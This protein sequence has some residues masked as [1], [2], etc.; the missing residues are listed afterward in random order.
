MADQEWWQ[1]LNQDQGA[2]AHDRLQA[3]Q[4]DERDDPYQ[5]AAR[6]Q[7]A[8]EALQAPPESFRGYSPG[9]DLGDILDNPVTDAA[10]W[11]L[12][13][14]GTALDT[15]ARPVRTGIDEA[16]NL[17]GG[18][19]TDPYRVLESVWNPDAATSA[20]SLRRRFLFKDIGEE[21]DG[22]TWGDVPDVLADLG[23]ATVTDPLSFLLPGASKAGEAAAVGGRKLVGALSQA[24]R[25]APEAEMLSNL[26]K[27][28]VEG[29]EAASAGPRMKAGNFFRRAPEELPGYG[30]LA[31]P[32]REMAQA[33]AIREAEAFA[34]KKFT[35]E[36]GNFL[37]QYGTG[38][39]PRP[40]FT[41]EEPTLYQRYASGEQNV[42]L[43]VPFVSSLQTG[44]L[45]GPNAPQW[46][47][48]GLNALGAA[49]DAPRQLLG[50]IMEHV[51][52]A[53]A[54]GDYILAGPYKAMTMLAQSIP[55]RWVGDKV[56][57]A[58]DLFLE[59]GVLN[60]GGRAAAEAEQFGAKLRTEVEPRIFEMNEIAQKA[61]LSAEERQL[62]NGILPHYDP[63]NPVATL[64][65]FDADNAHVDAGKATPEQQFKKVSD[66]ILLLDKDK[67]NAI[68]AIAQQHH[69]M[70][71]RLDE[72]MRE[73]GVGTGRLGDA[74][75]ERLAKF[76]A[77]RESLG[78]K[79]AGVQKKYGPSET[80]VLDHP[81]LR[82]YVDAMEP[83]AKA[84][85][86]EFINNFDRTQNE[87]FRSNPS[88]AP[89]QGD[90]VISVI[91]KIDETFSRAHGEANYLW[92]R[93]KYKAGYDGEEQIQGLIRQSMSEDPALK[94]LQ[95]QIAHGSE[96]L[97]AVMGG[98][99]GDANAIRAQID[100]ANAAIT[101]RTGE[102]EQGVRNARGMTE[103]W[104][105]GTNLIR[106]LKGADLTTPLHE[107]AHVVRHALPEE[108]LKA[109][110]TWLKTAH[111]IDVEK[112]WTREADEM[113]AKYLERYFKTGKAPT[114]E[115]DGVFA[116]L[117]KW[118]TEIYEHIKEKMG[119]EI[120]P[121][122]KAHFD[123]L[124]G[125]V[126]DEGRAF[127]K[128]GQPSG[129][130][131]AGVREHSVGGTPT[132]H[133]P[134]FQKSSNA[135]SKLVQGGNTIDDQINKL[136]WQIDNHFDPYGAPPQ[137][138]IDLLNALKAEKASRGTS[139]PGS[140]GPKGSAP[141][142]ETKWR[143]DAQ[144]DK[145][146][147]RPGLPAAPDEFERTIG[148]LSDVT[149]FPPDTLTRARYDKN[150]K[151]VEHTFKAG[152]MAGYDASKRGGSYDPNTREA[153][154]ADKESALHEAMHIFDHNTGLSAEGNYTG[155]VM[156]DEFVSN[157]VQG[158]RA[159]VPGL[160]PDAQK[161]YQALT[162]VLADSPIFNKHVV[163][164]DFVDN[165]IPGVAARK[166]SYY[167]LRPER[168]ARAMEV[169]LAQHPQFA[170]LKE[171]IKGP[172]FPQGEEAERIA[173][174]VNA[175]IAAL[176]PN[177]WTDAKT[178]ET[179]YGLHQ[180]GSRKVGE[181]ISQ[182]EFESFQN[183]LA[184]YFGHPRK[185]WG[186]EGTIK[187]VSK[188]PN[189]KVGG[190]YQR[191]EGAA[192]EIG[193]EDIS[194]A[195]HELVG[196]GL[197]EQAYKVAMGDRGK[198]VAE[199]MF[200]DGLNYGGD[201]GELAHKAYLGSIAPD[202]TGEAGFK[203]A[204][205]KMRPEMQDALTDLGRFFQSKELYGKAPVA[206]NWHRNLLAADERLGRRYASR[207][208]EMFAR[209]MEMGLA[210]KPEFAHYFEGK[211]QGNA[212]YPQGR[213]AEEA[214]KVAERVL[215]TLR[216]YSREVDGKTVFGL[217]QP[218]AEKV[219]ESVR[220]RMFREK[221]TALDSK[222]E[223]LQNVINVTQKKVN[224]IPNYTP[225]IISDA[226]RQQ[227]AE[228][229]GGKRTP[230][231]PSIGMPE[232][233][234]VG[235]AGEGKRNVMTREQTT[236]A[237]LPDSAYERLSARM[238]KGQY[239]YVDRELERL[240]PA[241]SPET[242]ASVQ[243]AL[244]PDPL[245]DV[246]LYPH[247]IEETFARGG[248]GTAATAG[249]G[250]LEPAFAV[251]DVVKQAFKPEALTKLQ[252][253]MTKGLTF[254]KQDPIE[255]IAKKF[256]GN[257]LP[258]ATQAEM[259]QSFARTF[260]S[261]PV[262]AVNDVIAMAKEGRSLQ[263]IEKAFKAQGY[264]RIEDM[265]SQ[266]VWQGL[267]EGRLDA[268]DVFGAGF[269]PYGRVEMPDF[270]P[271]PGERGVQEAHY[272]SEP[273]AKEFA[274]QT[275]MY[276]DLG[277]TLGAIQPMIQTGLSYWK[278]FQT[279]Y[280]LRYHIRN[281]ISDGTRMLQMGAIDNQTMGDIA[282]LYNPAFWKNY[283]STGLSRLEPWRGVQFDIGQ[284]A[285]FFGGRNIV[286]GEEIMKLL[287]EKGVLSSGRE[288]QELFNATSKALKPGQKA[289][290]Y[291]TGVGFLDKAK[292]ALAYRDEANR[293]A[294]FMTFLRKGQSVDTA[295]ISTTRTLFDY[296]KL[297][298]AMDFLRK[299]GIAPFIGWAAKN[300]PAQVDFALK[301]PG[302]VAGVF[303]ATQ[304]AQDGSLPPEAM[305]S[306]M[307]NKLGIRMGTRTNSATGREE[308]VVYGVGG[309]I[310]LLDL[311]EATNDPK[312]V[313]T[314]QL[315]P[316]LKYGLDQM[317]DETPDEQLSS[318]VGVPGAIVS[319]AYG[320]LTGE[321][322]PGGEK[323]TFGELGLSL[324]NPASVKP[325]DVKRAVLRADH[326]AKSD[327]RIARSKYIQTQA[328]LNQAIATFGTED[329]S[330]EPMKRAKDMAKR[331]FFA[332]KARM[333]RVEQQLVRQQAVP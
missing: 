298:P 311:V 260:Q 24:G 120:T 61:G 230:G 321:I 186:F 80:P 28:G 130:S 128:A 266:D 240:M 324:I 312:G 17:L 225:T 185:A 144:E 32:S 332:A 278:P 265:L 59:P 54:A 191:G 172:G 152:D 49:A 64:R 52:G 309:I 238:E 328:R 71:Y 325:V 86:G 322:G 121:D 296:K 161:A 23:V 37:P 92:K 9:W 138:T 98:A 243:K 218:S 286:S 268:Q 10:K 210:R 157:K 129:R 66:R 178:G 319:K 329:P 69:A 90:V 62:A 26:G 111:G 53:R 72:V 202:G 199:N 97:K 75:R 315:A 188:A 20:T 116:K 43:G 13:A 99:P 209:L 48:T 313:I 104:P 150:N 219:F 208:D 236:A 154:I 33:D 95:Q 87:G 123:R 76:K 207:P 107:M 56:Q 331:E 310:P 193:A 114:A 158:A 283:A 280:T 67:Q 133:D 141:T 21:G 282:K 204:L 326:D 239:K 262:R 216:P 255:A 16:A 7:I 47:K 317:M 271:K 149:G 201:I 39:A 18:R 4:M 223:A 205:S 292:R 58:A 106:A 179:V 217:Y 137:A 142:S 237:G 131:P 164:L 132:T 108:E 206:P 6:Q 77:E 183:D 307:R 38:K 41:G 293:V 91:D 44:P 294:S 241:A 212:W 42:Q 170:W 113:Y 308:A 272:L 215:D 231:D 279:A 264:G 159:N 224:A 196:H 110:A 155:H 55:A 11:G 2:S 277:G 281:T 82:D 19:Q 12:G 5:S 1:T 320:A 162:D 189:D 135:P 15:L 27:A 146:A 177:A 297:S 125:G 30:P 299:M 25:L 51:P 184:D 79:R 94:Q 289:S 246:P 284:G 306:Y 269:T 14:A 134:A 151:L 211:F 333:E 235:R 167:S 304:M 35:D 285:Q 171:R 245:E 57:A 168:F 274:Q 139:A 175:Y 247:E 203:T 234:F 190:F 140:S 148:A 254:A 74:L 227:L 85:R 45:L 34:G 233:G 181:S 81:V 195:G 318:I 109:V 143:Y 276:K 22:T 163:D 29:L 103:Q 253:E 314:G 63:E 257:V 8:Q 102:I 198:D 93:L 220:Q 96:D 160:N 291:A 213:E 3:L 300:I 174:A 156:G 197:G 84:S 180:L 290:T 173:G 50:G 176:K 249:R 122:I 73:S 119:A 65:T 221:S 105:D 251:N 288:A 115:L 229:V 200:K 126:D 127:A 40:T 214:S 256:Y 194:A 31:T 124:L 166:K 187:H 330:L 302:I 259:R 252:D 248:T 222:I 316:W 287:A 60:A 136:Q 327:E 112:G 305:P 88:K 83:E 250:K 244:M 267:K 145:W 101:K 147:K 78:T 232:K 301:N 165:T 303:R 70:N 323:R 258:T 46:A 68:Y 36:T 192:R 273:A 263:E 228:K 295:V 153:F 275:A 182:G 270:A 169:G 226:A 100:T 118:I 242:R 261:V 117:K 89:L